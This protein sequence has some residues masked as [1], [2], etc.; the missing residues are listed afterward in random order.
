MDKGQKEG[1]FVHAVI[2]LIRQ[3]G[4]FLIEG[5]ASFS[6]DSRLANQSAVELLFDLEEPFSDCLSD[7][8]S[9]SG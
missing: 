9:F 4:I 8:F 5:S 2:L 3:K 6:I 7:A 1:M